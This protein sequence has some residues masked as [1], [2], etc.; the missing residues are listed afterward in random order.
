MRS[1]R[2]TGLSL[3]GWPY[4]QTDEKR[5]QALCDLQ[6]S[7]SGL[8]CTIC[9]RTRKLSI[10]HRT[11]RRVGLSALTRLKSMLTEEEFRGYC[12]GQAIAYLWREKIQGRGYGLGQGWLVLPQASAVKIDSLDLFLLAGITFSATG[13]STQANWCFSIFGVLFVVAILNA[14]LGGK[15]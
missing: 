9:P 11:T 13:H 5:L 14:L 2:T 12:K 8:G 6:K 7:H 1:G 10:S 15:R 3:T 4:A